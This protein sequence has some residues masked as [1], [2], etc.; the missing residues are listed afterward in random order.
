LIKL[1]EIAIKDDFSDIDVKYTPEYY[2]ARA[3]DKGG[4]LSNL[5]E[6]NYQPGNET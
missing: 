6:M 5:Q 4:V 1:A 2:A 3:K